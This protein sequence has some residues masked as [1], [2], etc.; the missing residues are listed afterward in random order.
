MLKV[1]SVLLFGSLFVLARLICYA[2]A[3]FASGLAG[4]LAFAATAVFSALAEVSCLKSCDSF[5]NMY[6]RFFDDA[7]YCTIVS[8]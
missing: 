2:A 3:C 7:I 6:L 5:H 8:Q 1:L 4:C